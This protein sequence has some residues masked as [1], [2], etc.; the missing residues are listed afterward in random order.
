MEGIRHSAEKSGMNPAN[1]MQKAMDE[2]RTLR[3]A[4]EILEA[5]VEVMNIFRDAVRARPPEYGYA[6]G[7]IDVV[8]EMQEY[9][10]KLEVA[11]QSNPD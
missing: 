6:G 7:Q 9:L 3:R 8:W 10:K 4:N 11:S 2:I 1:L 5:K